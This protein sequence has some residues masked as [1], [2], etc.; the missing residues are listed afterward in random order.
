MKKESI[1]SRISDYTSSVGDERSIPVGSRTGLAAR[2]DAMSILRSRGFSSRAS[3]TLCSVL[4]AMGAALPPAFAQMK[5]GPPPGIDQVTFRL[6]IPVQ[7]NFVETRTVRKYVDLGDNKPAEEQTLSQT[8]DVVIRR[9]GTGFVVSVRPRV[10]REWEAPGG[11]AQGLAAALRS[12]RLQYEFDAQGKLVALRGL[13]ALREELASTVPTPMKPM[14]GALLPAAVEQMKDEWGSRYGPLVDATFPVGYRQRGEMPITLVPGGPPVTA[15]IG[16]GV[17]RR[18][19]CN[20]GLCVVFV[21][22]YVVENADGYGEAISRM[23]RDWFRQ[24]LLGLGGPEAKSAIREM[25]AG[26]PTLRVT[27]LVRATERL[28]DPQT[29]MVHYE[30]QTKGFK[31]LYDGGKEV[32]WVEVTTMEF[33]RAN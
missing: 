32:H 33:K 9:R 15:K 18:E 20:G 8:S 12:M 31:A 17:T 2:G 29:M 21:M 23:L 30:R 5:G 26:I 19:P 25:E 3:R 6:A 16:R 10:A 27:E 24:M 4:F 1:V 28:V 11:E 7:A 22:G 14:L 13:E